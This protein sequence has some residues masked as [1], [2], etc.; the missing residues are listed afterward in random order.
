MNYTHAFAVPGEDS[1]IDCINP[2]TG[3]SCING[4]TLEQI[5]LRYPK[6][7]IVSME[8]F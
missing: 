1:I 2:N 5:R 8:A 4:E 7:E 3:N 6:A